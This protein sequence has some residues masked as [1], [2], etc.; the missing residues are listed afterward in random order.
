MT[1]KVGPKL[2]SERLYR[3]SKQGQDLSALPAPS[4]LRRHHFLAGRIRERQKNRS[5]TILPE[6]QED[7]ITASHTKKLFGFLS[8]PE[9]G[10][11][12]NTENLL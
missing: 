6:S 12:C 8:D 10:N 4:P 3:L 11:E 7:S 1:N 9:I 2:T 5:L